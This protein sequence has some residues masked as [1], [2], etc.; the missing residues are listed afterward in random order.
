[1]CFFHSYIAPLS[2][3]TSGNKTQSRSTSPRINDRKWLNKRLNRKKTETTKKKRSKREEEGEKGKGEWNRKR[4]D[5][6]KIG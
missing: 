2:A 6:Y 1:M 5:G 3:F 4:E